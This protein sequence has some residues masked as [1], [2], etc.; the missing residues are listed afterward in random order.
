MTTLLN[1]EEP[2]LLIPESAMPMFEID[3]ADNEL[4]ST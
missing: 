3:T 1:Y 2:E 4:S